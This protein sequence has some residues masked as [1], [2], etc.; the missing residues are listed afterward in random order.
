[1]PC[2]MGTLFGKACRCIACHREA[3]ALPPAAEDGGEGRDVGGEGAA[4]AAE[5]VVSP[6]AAAAAAAAEAA[7]RAAAL[8][9]VVDLSGLDLSLLDAPQ[10]MPAV[11]GRGQGRASR[12]EGR[13]EG[14]PGMSF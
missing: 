8:E 11:S 9:S 1:M 4:A 12:K 6:R 7:E 13:R 10:S 3:A 14:C 5:P 2:S